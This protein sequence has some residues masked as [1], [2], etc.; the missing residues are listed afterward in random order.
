MLYFR[1]V[2]CYFYHGIVPCFYKNCY[3]A[4]YT[5][6]NRIVTVSAKS[7]INTVKKDT[8]QPLLRYTVI[9]DY[10]IDKFF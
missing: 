6:P 4:P 1:V 8:D 9:N 10:I 7:F 3:Y 2:E 5:L